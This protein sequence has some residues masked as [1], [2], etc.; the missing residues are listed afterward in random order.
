M[1]RDEQTPNAP[2]VQG[3]PI[4]APVSPGAVSNWPMWLLGFVTLVD[5]LDQ[6]IIRGIEKQLKLEFG[7]TDIMFGVLLSSFILVNGLVTVPAGYLAD[8]LNRTRTIGNTVI[9]WSAVTALTAA[10]PNFGSMLAIRSSLGFGQAVT[11]P[12][13]ASLIG[14]YYPVER[15]GN[16]F[17]IQLVCMLAGVGLGITFGGLIGSTIGWRWAYLMVAPVGLVIAYAAHRLGEPSRG[18]ADMVHAGAAVEGDGGGLNV[19]RPPLFEEGIGTFMKQLLHGLRNDLRVIFSIPTMRYALGGVIG[20]F[21]T[22]NAVGSWLAVY[23]QREFGLSEL[24]ATASLGAIVLLGGVP[25]IIL[26]GRLADYY[27]T[28]M[29]GARMAIPGYC[30]LGSSTF[31]TL[32]YLARSFWPAYVLGFIGFSSVCLAGPALRAGLSDAVPH[33]LRGAGFGAFN[34]MGMTLG[35]ASAPLVVSV[36][37]QIFDN[38]LRTAF[39]IVSPPILLASWLLLRARNHIDDDMAK[40]F[41]AVLTA[42]QEQHAEEE[43]RR[44]G[45]TPASA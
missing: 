30:L 17:S 14:D 4:P 32:S 10:M 19:E 23:Y 27:A 2:S 5:Q 33:N 13:T 1:E 40:I 41:E 11:E 39:L 29:R 36:L 3:T 28:R 31:L 43:A 7:L 16:A 6:N 34:L 45:G 12:A 35:A 38:N 15:R 8:R 24:R 22:M 25:C 9:G 21:F 18:H 20:V 37:S 26:G 44:S 42:V